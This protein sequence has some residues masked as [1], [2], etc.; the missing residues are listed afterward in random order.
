MPHAEVDGLARRRGRLGVPLMLDESLCSL[1]DAQRAIEKGTCDLFNIRLSKCGGFVPSLRIAAMAHR[2]GWVTS[3]GAR[4]ARRAFCRQPA[5]IS[6]PRSPAS[7][8]SKEASTD[9]SSPSG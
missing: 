6:P 5:G 2:A 4:S 8:T 7:A 3:L 1:S 9:S